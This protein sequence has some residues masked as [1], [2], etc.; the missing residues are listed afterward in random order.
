MAHNV[1]ADRRTRF[2]DA[3]EDG[4]AVFKSWP[5]HVRNGDVDH[6]Y[7]TNS[8]LFLLTGF[9]EPE[10]MAVLVKRGADRKYVLFVRPRDPEMET[11]VGK[12][13]GTEGAISDF[14]ADEAYDSALFFDRLPGLLTNQ[15]RLYLEFGLDVAFEGRVSLAIEALKG[16]ARKGLC[17]PWQII[18]PRSILWD[19]RVVKSA[20][21]V[22]VIED[23][24]AITVAAF[25]AAMQAA[26][27]GMNEGELAAVVEFEFRRRGAHRV[28]FETIC[29]SGANAATL[30]YIRNDATLG[31]GD[32]VLIDAGAERNMM[33]AD[34]SR[35]F[36]TNGRFTPLQRRVYEWVLKAQEAAI[37]AVKPGT[38]YAKVHEA[39]LKVLVEGLVDLGALKGKPRSLIE[40][41]AYRPYFMHRIGHWLGSDVHDVGPYF[42]DGASIPLRAGMVITIEPGLYFADAPAT[43]KA[44]R[45]IGIRIEDDVL[46]TDKGR[47]VLT[48]ALPK[49]VD[50][51]EALMADRGAWW[52]TVQPV[53][54]PAGKKAKKSAKPE[55]AGKAKK[56]SS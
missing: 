35:T 8:D 45:G 11:W 32:L 25:R 16:E 34:I 18:D 55:K 38:T 17:G 36:P 29:A 41:G 23:A 46:V 12:R 6:P 43:P 50:D 19:M 13:A 33:S 7:R 24:C 15:P 52:R 26:T 44:L 14:G 42:V 37:A 47:R 48:E 30:H 31:D 40:T 21:D 10:T 9:D 27:P 2:L 53:T 1:F 49:T 22:Q 39:G 4:V 20:H 3:M 28:A 5:V 56:K 54:V 51:I